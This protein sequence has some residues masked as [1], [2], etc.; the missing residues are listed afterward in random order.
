MY[1]GF[2]ICIPW[3]VGGNEQW[4]VS[5]RKVHLTGL[6]DRLIILDFM[7]LHLRFFSIAD[8]FA[9]NLKCLKNIKHFHCKKKKRLR[10]AELA[11]NW[12]IPVLTLK[13]IVHDYFKNQLLFSV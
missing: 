8:L 4:E 2:K 1:G 11:K 12:D 10:K 3:M 9:E 6:S 5:L 7:F 13:K